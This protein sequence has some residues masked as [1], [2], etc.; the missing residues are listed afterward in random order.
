FLI[1]EKSMRRKDIGFFARLVGAVPV[2]RALDMTKPATGT[3][4]LPDPQNNPLILRGN[5]TKFTTE[6]SVGGL[7][8][9]PTSPSGASAATG[10]IAEIRSDEEILLKKEI[11]GSDAIEQLAQEGEN[12]KGTKFKVA[13]KVDQTQVYEA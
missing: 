3:I 8:V 9:L 4:Y 7:L 12:G 10:E 1:A 2:A 11:K 6:A 5:G 13:P